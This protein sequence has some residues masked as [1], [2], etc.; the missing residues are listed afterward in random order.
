ME[1]TSRAERAAQSAPP[2]PTIRP[3]K[4][5]ADPN[6]ALN[7]RGALSELEVVSD[8]YRRGYHV[9]RNVASH[10]P[11]DLVAV[12]TEGDVFLV[13]VTTGAR[14]G[15]RTCRSHKDVGLW[16]LLAVS[17]PDGVGYYRRDGSKVE[18]ADGEGSWI[19]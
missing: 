4:R 8:L 14:S 7:S 11:I 10:G 19:S 18:L 6:G 12:S 17:C 16:N 5:W 1:F 2:L 3:N 13:Q 15:A 9:F